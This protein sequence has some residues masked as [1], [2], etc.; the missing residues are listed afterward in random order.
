MFVG[1]SLNIASEITLLVSMLLL[2]ST[3]NNSIIVSTQIYFNGENAEET[4]W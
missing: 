2:T 1:Y 4:L 3:H